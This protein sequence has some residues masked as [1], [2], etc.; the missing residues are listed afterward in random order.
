MKQ[1]STLFL[2]TAIILIGIPVF[3]LCIFL[4][5][6]IGNYAADLYPDIAY[7]KY[8]VLINLYATVIPF[9]FALYQAF[10]LVSYIDKGNAFSKLSVRALKKIKQCAITIS[11]LYVVGMPLFYL[12]A[13]R[14][15]A[16]G[17]IIIGMILIFSSMVIAVFAA[18]L[19][20]L[21]K[22]AIDIKSENDLTV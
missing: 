20:R 5:P 12:V 14:D 15:D 22:D 21:L 16:P 19:Q 4:I 1:G 18:V 7:I 9:Y 3:A 6:N 10:K 2:K 13:E 8:L 17:I 11:V